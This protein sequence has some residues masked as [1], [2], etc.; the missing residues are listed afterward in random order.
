MNITFQS[1]N[2]KASKDLEEFLNKRLN[3]LYQQNSKID[4][5]E[6]TLY[7]RATKTN[8]KSH[9]CE[10][11]LSVNGKIHFVKKVQIL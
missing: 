9:F 11:Y 3:K 10:I 2:F 4:N 6:V 8:L 1:V 5:V 7:E